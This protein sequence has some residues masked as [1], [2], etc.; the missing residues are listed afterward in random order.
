MKMWFWNLVWDIC[1]YLEAIAE[2][3]IVDIAMKKYNSE[4]EK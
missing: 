3:K 1:G 4:K 2:D